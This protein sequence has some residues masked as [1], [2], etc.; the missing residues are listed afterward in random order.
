VPIAPQRVPIVKMHGTRNDFVL[1]DERPPHALDYGRL[2]RRWCDRA[3]DVGADGLLVILPP[4]TDALATMRIFNADGSEAE[5]CGNGVRCVARYLWEEGGGA[6]FAV[7]T[8]AGRIE[9]DVAEQ[10]PDVSVRVELVPPRVQRPYG[11]GASIDALGAEWRYAQI[12]LGNPHIV[13]FVDDPATID[14][15]AL[16]GALATHPR[17]PEGTNVHVGAALDRRTIAVRHFERGVGITKACGT[18]AVAAAVAA[19]EDGRVASPVRVEVPGGALEVEWSPGAAAFLSGPAEVEF[20]RT[21][22]VA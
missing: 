10:G 7:D 3:G 22:D 9:L 5:M 20:E 11:E 4:S 19:I 2:A 1:L 16:G 14:L 6:H 17:F 13:I 18:G 21:L 15:A 8:L 12:S